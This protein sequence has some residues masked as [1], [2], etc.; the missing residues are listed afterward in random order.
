MQHGV[1]VL[2]EHEA[3]VFLDAAG[4]MADELAEEMQGGAQTT[5]GVRDF[6]RLEPGRRL[7]LL[8]DVL[9]ALLEEN[10]AAPLPT[11]FT[12]GTIDAILNHVQEMIRQE[13]EY[14]LLEG[15]HP[16]F[17]VHS[18]RHV[19]HACT[20][21]RQSPTPN[22]ESL[23]LVAWNRAIVSL[24]DRVVG[25]SERKPPSE[26]QAAEREAIERVKK[27][28]RDGCCS[29]M[30]AEPDAQ[31]ITGLWRRLHAYTHVESWAS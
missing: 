4:M 19:I 18:W 13:V 6:D 2:T 7:R 21:S 25:G 12:Q 16:E 11:A 20:A 23:D 29:T 9:T 3:R 30:L 17:D 26:I 15:T 24:R 8:T 5:Y 14:E 31:E 10:V 27:S 1:G 22:L 28:E